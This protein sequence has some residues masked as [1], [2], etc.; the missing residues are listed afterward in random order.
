MDAADII[1]TPESGVHYSEI[2]A[3]MIRSRISYEDLSKQRGDII[4]QRLQQWYCLDA[5]LYDD[6]DDY[7][8]NDVLLRTCRLYDGKCTWHPAEDDCLVARRGKP[9]EGHS[10]M[11]VVC[12][13]KSKIGVSQ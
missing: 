12:I 8:N 3:S 9:E 10:R 2:L 11:A 7:D 4:E 13:R 1:C 5:W 6:D